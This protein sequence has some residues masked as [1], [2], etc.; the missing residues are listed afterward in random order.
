MTVYSVWKDLIKPTIFAYI[1][2]CAVLAEI[3]GVYYLYA[4]Y[5]IVLDIF[6]GAQPQR[7]T[8]SVQTLE[9]S[10]Y[11]AVGDLVYRFATVSGMYNN[12]LK[13]YLQDIIDIL[14][15]YLAVGVRELPEYNNDDGD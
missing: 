1:M 7:V 11:K 8:Q 6:A 14:G 3:A 10:I 13:H 12:D 15:S 4:N 2:V 9:L 5:S